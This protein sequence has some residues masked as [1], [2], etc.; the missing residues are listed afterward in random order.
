MN[1]YLKKW[2]KIVE[3][4]VPKKAAKDFNKIKTLA[5]FDFDD[6]LFRSPQR[7]DDYKGNWHIKSDSLSPPAVPRVPKQ[8]MWHVDIVN[9]AKKYC[10]KE[11]AYCIM[12]TGRVG[13]VFEDRIKELISQQEISFDQYGFNEFGGDTAKYKIQTINSLI[14]KIPKL[15]NL[16]MWDDDEEKIEK[17]KE[18]FSNKEYKFVINHVTDEPKQIKNKIIN[19]RYR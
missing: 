5:V 7:P 3:S 1:I 2:D 14:D 18:V 16:I 15:N 6:T 17:Y 11:D 4:V 12:L 10:L 13:N 19:I 8:N 9:Q